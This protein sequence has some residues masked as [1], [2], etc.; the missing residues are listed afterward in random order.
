MLTSEEVNLELTA[1]SNALED[2]ESVANGDCS[3]DE[4]SGVRTELRRAERVLL[5][6]VKAQRGE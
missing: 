5:N 2:F 6:I 1:V 4:V 3:M